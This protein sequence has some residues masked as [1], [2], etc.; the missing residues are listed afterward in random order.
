MARTVSAQPLLN[1]E[2]MITIEVAAELPMVTPKDRARALSRGRRRVGQREPSKG[3]S[4][5]A[6]LRAQQ[7]RHREV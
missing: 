4:Q 2:D 3:R 7:W 1:C 5:C 6:T